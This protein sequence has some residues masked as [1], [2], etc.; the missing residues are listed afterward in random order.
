MT[1]T[2]TV[3]RHELLPAV[4]YAKAGIPR[5][6]APV[7]KALPVAARPGALVISGFNYEVLHQAEVYAR[8]RMSQMQHPEYV[9]VDAGKLHAAVKDFPA[10]AEVRVTVEDD[11]S[12]ALESGGRSAVLDMVPGAGDYPAPPDTIPVLG[13]DAGSGPASAWIPALRGC[14]DHAAKERNLRPDSEDMSAVQF[15][16][17][18][19]G[20][21]WVSGRDRHR[22]FS[23]DLPWKGPAGA[24]MLVGA[25]ELLPFLK[26]VRSA[27]KDEDERLYAWVPPVG[28][29]LD[30]ARPGFWSYGDAG[31]PWAFFLAAGRILAVRTRHQAVGE[32]ARFLS[33]PGGLDDRVT[34]SGKDLSY[35]L[36]RVLKLTGEDWP[37]ADMVSGHGRLKFTA[38]A[39]WGGE[40][41]L[42]GTVTVPCDARGEGIEGRVN[43]AHL[44]ELVRGADGPVVLGPAEHQRGDGTVVTLLQVEAPAHRG[45]VIIRRQ[46]GDTSPG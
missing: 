40:D 15:A 32:P 1:V 9:L 5:R 45:A 10:D 7:L 11:R 34:A 6:S 20:R 38:Y 30:E 29:R 35:A 3:P 23:A 2:Y 42:A 36:S 13:R 18:P 43:P 25:A 41:G 28:R 27:A 44:H 39:G 12:L 19:E 14:A 22:V 24:A 8:A 17:T 37:A 46:A 4:A 16:V 21:M 26:S 33:P 31:R